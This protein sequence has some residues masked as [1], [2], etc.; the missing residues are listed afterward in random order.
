MRYF[1]ISIQDFQIQKLLYASLASKVCLE[2]ALF[3]VG[4]R[5]N[6]VAYSIH[7]GQH[8][9]A[10]GLFGLDVSKISSSYLM[11][12]AA[13]DSEFIFYLRFSCC[14]NN[15]GWKSFVDVLSKVLLM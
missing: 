5:I 13:R 12:R 15:V 6:V 3:T 4:T 14:G 9:F 8:R 2:S 11:G 7:R 10:C 1:L